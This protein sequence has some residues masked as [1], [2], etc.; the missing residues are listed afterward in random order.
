MIYTEYRIK[1][2]NNFIGGHTFTVHELEFETGKPPILISDIKI[3][4]G[5]ILE[6]EAYLRLK[7]TK[8]L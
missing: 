6:C 1:E 2:K 8:E 5:T 3:F 4:G 7:K